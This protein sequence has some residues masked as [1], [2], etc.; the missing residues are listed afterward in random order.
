MNTQKI[1]IE[2]I[3]GLSPLKK[4]EEK[5]ISDYLKKRIRS[6]KKLKTRKNERGINQEIE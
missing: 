5:L 1:D 4:T 6:K 2:K 3:G